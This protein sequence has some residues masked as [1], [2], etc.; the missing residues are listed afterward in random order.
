MGHESIRFASQ[1]MRE[2]AFF[3]GGVDYGWL[4]Y[5][6]YKQENHQTN[7]VALELGEKKA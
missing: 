2:S 4:T 7:R 3:L 6:S 5:K 1:M